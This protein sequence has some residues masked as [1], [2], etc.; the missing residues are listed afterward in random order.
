VQKITIVDFSSAWVMKDVF[1]IARAKPG[2]MSREDVL[3]FYREQKA[4]GVE[5]M[6]DYWHDCSPKLLKSLTDDVGLPVTCYVFFTDFAVSKTDLKAKI[7]QGKDLLDRTAAIGTPRA[8]IVPAVYKTDTPAIDQTARVVEGLRACAEHAQTLGITL[9]AENI[10]YPPIRPLMGRG[11]QCRDICAAV[12]SPAF[13]LIYDA[14]CSLAVNEDPIETLHV[15]APYLAHV[16]LK[17][18]RLM[19]LGETRDRFLNSDS[20]QTYVS[21]PLSEGIVDIGRVLAELDKLSYTGLLLLEYQGE[22]PLKVLPQDLEFLRS[23]GEQ[24]LKRA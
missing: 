11:S 5:L 18:S 24:K 2:W 7:D 16:H 1:Q 17:N 6:H 15:M 14:G 23:F 9:M 20:S 4:E 8:M 13:R 12:D 22:D 3:K 10:D 19:K 21:T